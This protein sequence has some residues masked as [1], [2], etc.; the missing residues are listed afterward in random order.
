MVN[1]VIVVINNGKFIAI[2]SLIGTEKGEFDGVV[3]WVLRNWS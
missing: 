2:G 1:W 3:N